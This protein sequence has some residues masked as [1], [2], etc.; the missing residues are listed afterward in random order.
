MKYASLDGK[1][2]EW[3]WN[4][5]DGVSPFIVR[6][7]SG[8]EMNHTQWEYDVR[9]LNYRPLEGERVFVDA[10]PE[11]LRSR[12]EEMIKRQ[13]PTIGGQNLVEQV[14]NTLKSWCQPGSPLIVTAEE[15]YNICLR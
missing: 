7:K 15:Y 10:R 5:R 2:V 11:L 9:I 13:D 6:S 1:E 14:N 4:S 8:K 3:I 12:A